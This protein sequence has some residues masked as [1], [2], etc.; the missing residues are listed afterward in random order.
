[1]SLFSRP[2]ANDIRLKMYVYG[3]T[4][5]G[6]TITALNFPDPI[7]IDTEKGSEHYRK[8]YGE[9]PVLYSMDSNEIIAAIDELLVDPQGHKTFV[10][11]SFT[12][13]YDSI[14]RAREI[15]V[16]R[17][18]GDDNYEIQ[19]LDYRYIKG[20]TQLISEKMLSLDMNLIVTARSKNVY[21]KGKFMEVEGTAAEGDKNLPYL[22]DVVI[23]LKIEGDK[24]VAYVEK[25]R[26]N[27]L[28]ATFEYNYDN[29]VEYIGLENL[30]KEASA[31][32]QKSNIDFRKSRTTYITV[33]GEK[34][35]TA[36]ITA[37]DLVAIST[38]TDI[39]ETDDFKEVL[40]EQYQVDSLLDLNKKE[41]QALL[42][43]LQ[44]QTTSK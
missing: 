39:I 44:K 22:F 18:T 26:T 5:T 19:P 7:V 31:D 21:A 30:N 25:D 13:L 12:R 6:K 4:G 3:E 8:D 32:K 34:M 33:S 23:E 16:R 37:A 35:K 20:V 1:M 15:S 36:G 2:P 10:L 24:R 9:F 38:F 27:K 41:G 42:A 14:V 29:L 43:Y 40:L 11:D 17:R 28:P